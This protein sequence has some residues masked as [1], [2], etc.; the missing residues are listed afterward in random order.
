[1]EDMKQKI[2]GRTIEISNPHKVFYPN[3]NITKGE[4]L[5]YYNRIAECM[6]PHIRNRLVVMQRFPE[7]IGKE[8]FYH[9]QVPDYFPEWLQRKTVT[10]RKGEKQ[11]IAVVNKKAD[12]IYM[13]EQG[14]ITYH[15]W[16]SQKDNIG[17]PD[18]LVFDLDPP[19]KGEFSEVKFAAYKLRDLFQDMGLIPYVMTTGSKGLH[20]VTPIKPEYDFD[21]IR[22]Y[23][24]DILTELVKKYPDR[25]TLE[26]R[27]DERQGRVFLDY[28]RHAFGQTSVAPYSL[29][30]IEGAPIATPL[31]WEKLPY[32]EN[33]QKYHM[34][35]IFKRLSQKKD[36]WKE[37]KLH[38]KS[39]DI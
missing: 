16:L 31:E 30:P 26:P 23:V 10:L 13:A 34:K 6:L 37:F 21:I 11:D 7:G 32:I 15:I 12:I 24:R 19:K 9:K 4:I 20:V 18:K 1:M 33:S 35:N 27:K 25:F 29:R 28:L 8:G 17:K 3:A 22:Q 14:T 5:N 38:R 36:P 2:N 39:L